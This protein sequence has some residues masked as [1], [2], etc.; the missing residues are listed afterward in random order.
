MLILSSY[1]HGRIKFG[2]SV[3]DYGFTAGIPLGSL[4]LFSGP[5]GVGKSVFLYTTIKSFLTR[6]SK[7]LLVCFDDDPRGVMTALKRLGVDIERYIK[8]NSIGIIDGFYHP[9]RGSIQQGEGVLAVVN[10]SDLNEVIEKIKL[11]IEKMGLKDGNGILAIDSLNELIMRNDV[12]S[13]IDFVKALRA[14]AK[15]RDILILS[16]L[17]LGMINVEN[18]IFALEYVSDAVVEFGLDPNLEQLGIPLRRLRVKKA[19]GV[20]HSLQWIPYTITDEGISLVD[21]EEL[22]SKL[23]SIISKLKE[24]GKEG[25]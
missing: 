2:I 15:Y 7:V 17:H 5:P 18:L 11:S 21:I 1:E 22:R 19:R 12:I 24:V 16:T 23:R 20:P 4:I 6:G 9:L 14:E 13:V 8:D 25:P 3:L 10:P